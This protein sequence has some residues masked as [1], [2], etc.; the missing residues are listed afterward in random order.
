M[1]CDSF[2]GGEVISYGARTITEGGLQCLPKLHMP[3]AM[4]AGDSAG[5]LIAA[6]IKGAHTAMKMGL[7]P[8]PLCVILIVGVTTE[9][10]GQF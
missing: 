2:A 6:R 8:C 3:G 5:T 4:L 1:L 9:V 10:D 7:L